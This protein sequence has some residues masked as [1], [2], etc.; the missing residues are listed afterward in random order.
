LK[1]NLPHPILLKAILEYKTEGRGFKATDV[2][3]IAG[4]GLKGNR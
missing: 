4:K 2:S 3:E 1:N